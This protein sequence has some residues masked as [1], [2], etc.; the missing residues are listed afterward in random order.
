ME[1]TGSVRTEYGPA[2]RYCEGWFLSTSRCDPS[3]WPKKHKIK[4]YILTL[5][6]E[7]I[8]SL[9]TDTQLRDWVTEQNLRHCR[10]RTLKTALWN[11][12]EVG[13][14]LFKYSQFYQVTWG[15]NIPSL[16]Q[17][18]VLR[19]EPKLY[20]SCLEWPQVSLP[21]SLNA[22]LISSLYLHKN[23]VRTWWIQSIQFAWGCFQTLLE[24]PQRKSQTSWSSP[25]QPHLPKSKQ[26]KVR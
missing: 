21:G 13:S 7:V 9:W 1:L 23:E 4:Q 15:L 5:H 20:C 12:E 6:R 24:K 17:C 19:R 22:K 2:P 25:S 18:Y 16:S 26:I 10:K 14:L 11:W 8:R 3:P